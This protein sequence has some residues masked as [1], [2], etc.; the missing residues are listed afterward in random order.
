MQQRMRYTR[1]LFPLAL[2][3]KDMATH[4][5]EIAERVRQ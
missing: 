3:L 5:A 4:L 2:E 1:E